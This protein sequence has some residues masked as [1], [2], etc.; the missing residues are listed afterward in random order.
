MMKHKITLDRFIGG[1]VKPWK[2]WK[3]WV[4]FLCPKLFPPWDH[5]LPLCGAVQFL[6]A[7][8]PPQGYSWK[9]NNRHVGLWT[10]RILYTSFPKRDILIFLPSATSYIFRNLSWFRLFLSC[11]GRASITDVLYRVSSRIAPPMYA[12]NPIIIPV[13]TPISQIH[14]HA[15]LNE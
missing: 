13:L 7:A 10:G 3:A 1:Q 8:S 4:S 15:I 9:K 6:S 2:S 14:N 5:P 12:I 11:S